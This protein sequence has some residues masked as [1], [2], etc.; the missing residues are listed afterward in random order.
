MNER[1]FTLLEVLVT[2][3]ILSI[4]LFITLPTLE[5]S[6]ERI[7]AMVLAK[8]VVSVLNQTR[9]LAIREGIPYSID[10]EESGE[11]IIRSEF[12][13]TCGQ[14]SSVN[15]QPHSHLIFF[16]NG[17]SNGGKLSI[18]MGRGEPYYEINIQ[19]LTGKISI[20]RKR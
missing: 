11:Y 15:I 17:T 6:Y 10:F 12:E 5:N 18:L 14:L 9:R 16:P 4:M 19:K 3:A 7:R 1:G 13:E 2:M 20:E 8:E